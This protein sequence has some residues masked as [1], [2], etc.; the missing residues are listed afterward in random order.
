MLLPTA[1]PTGTGL[2]IG[3]RTGEPA[4]YDPSGPDRD[5]GDFPTWAEAQDFYE[6]AGGPS[7]DRHRLDSDG[8]SVA[9]ESLSAALK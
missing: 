8:D 9:C 5:C 3:T 7:I 4:L 1:T 6:A 2:P